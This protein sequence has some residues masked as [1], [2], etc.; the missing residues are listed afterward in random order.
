MNPGILSLAISKIVE[1]TMF[2]NFGKATCQ[3]GDFKP[4]KIALK[5]TLC[6]ILLV[7]RS[8]LV[9]WLVG[10]YGISTFVG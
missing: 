10:F 7:E 2:F 3:G 9:G 5:V 1:Q 6:R 8:W 4:D